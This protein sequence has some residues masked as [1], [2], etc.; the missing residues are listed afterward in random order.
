MN[1]IERCLANKSGQLCP[2][3]FTCF[4]SETSNSDKLI[5][6]EFLYK[7]GCTNFL[8][9]YPKCDDGNPRLTAGESFLT[10]HSVG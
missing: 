9:A 6:A 1:T 7:Y 10:T 3:R 4:R 8:P 2:L 5:K